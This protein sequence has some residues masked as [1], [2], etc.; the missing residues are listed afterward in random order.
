MPI[1]FISLRPFNDIFP[2]FSTS[3]YGV[4]LTFRNAMSIVPLLKVGYCMA[5][6]LLSI[7]IILITGHLCLVTA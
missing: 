4:T 7:I 5:L 3:S 2:L 1:H 6:Y